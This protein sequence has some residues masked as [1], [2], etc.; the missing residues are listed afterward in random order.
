MKKKILKPWGYEILLEKNKKNVL[1]ELF[2]KA[3]HRC[4][5]QFHKKKMET[6]YVIKGKLKIKF[7]NKKK[8]RNKVFLKG[9]TI[10]IKPKTIHRMEAITDSIYLESSTP[11]LTDLVRLSDDYNRG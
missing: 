8:L 6:I 5:L 2:M 1:K 3:G 4:S 10:T 11:E 7:G 9:S